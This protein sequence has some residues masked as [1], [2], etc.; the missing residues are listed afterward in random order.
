MLLIKWGGK[1]REI[2]YVKVEMPYN[3][4]VSIGTYEGTKASLTKHF[5]FHWKLS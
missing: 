4:L 1:K 2:V 5:V 3:K